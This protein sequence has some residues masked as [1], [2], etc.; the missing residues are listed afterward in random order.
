MIESKNSRSFSRITLV[1]TKASQ[2]AEI[3]VDVVS[4]PK[5]WKVPDSESQYSHLNLKIHRLAGLFLEY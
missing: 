4:P 5:A 1:S 2:E 3:V